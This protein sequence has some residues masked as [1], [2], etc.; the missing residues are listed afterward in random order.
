MADLSACAE[1]LQKHRFDAK[2]FD[3]PQ[4]VNEALLTEIGTQSVG[5]G[6]SMTIQSLGVYDALKERGNKVFWHWFLPEGKTAPEIFQLA[7]QADVY[8]SSSNAVTE[9]GTLVNI[10]GT[11][12]RVAAMI[13]GPKRV[14]IVVGRNKIVPDYDNAIRRIHAVACPQNARRLQRKTPCAVGSCIDCDSPQRMC[15]I[16]THMTHAPNA[17]PVS[18]YLVDADMGY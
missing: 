15:H 6:A 17:H 7:A 16:T 12:N 11:G 2:V 14:I 4:A 8:L 3:S 1:A 10:D 9:D 18:V 5:F 13:C